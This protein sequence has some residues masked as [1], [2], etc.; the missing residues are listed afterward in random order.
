MTIVAANEAVRPACALIRRRGL[1][2]EHTV[3][4][5]EA[6]V[7]GVAGHLLE[8]VGGKQGFLLLLLRRG[9]QHADKI[10]YKEMKVLVRGDEVV[11]THA[12]QAAMSA[13]GFKRGFLAG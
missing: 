13:D 3:D 7:I 4:D 2:D 6:A 10:L 12:L 9:Q 11:F 1:D 5:S 8:R